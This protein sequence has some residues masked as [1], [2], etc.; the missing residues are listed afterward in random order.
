MNQ[1]IITLQETA[2][3]NLRIELDN[4]ED[5]REEL[6]ALMDKH[7]DEI[8]WDELLEPY[9]VNGSYSMVNPITIGALTSSPIIASEPA[10]YEDDGDSLPTLHPDAK[11]WWFPDYMVRSELQE[12]LDKGFVIFTT[13]I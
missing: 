1:K 8:V 11:T 6:E 12:L 5:A 10:M 13:T 2:G 4:T 3:G 9:Y 7:T